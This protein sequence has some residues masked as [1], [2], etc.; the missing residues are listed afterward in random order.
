MATW[1]IN[2][3]LLRTS[4]YGTP[5]GIVI[6]PPLETAHFTGGTGDTIIWHFHS[7]DSA[8]DEGEVEFD[9]GTDFFPN[10][11]KNK[12]TVNLSNTHGDI[13]GT[14]PDPG[15]D[16]TFPEKYTVRFKQSATTKEVEEDPMIIICR[17]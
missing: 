6:V 7:S 1:N 5:R 13:T 14:T 4:P 10:V 3:V 12:E 9:P 11:P 2:V 15:S 8:F 17:P 16:G